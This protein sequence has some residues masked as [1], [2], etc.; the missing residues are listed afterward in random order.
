MNI[1]IYIVMC[2]IY[3]YICTSIDVCIYIY[4]QINV[5][6]YIY[7]H[8]NYKGILVQVGISRV[9]GLPWTCQCTAT[10]RR[11]NGSKKHSFTFFDYGERVF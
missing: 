8:T 1:Y 9:S 6:V 2:V 5:C 7:M 3:I 11:R 4:I 10:T